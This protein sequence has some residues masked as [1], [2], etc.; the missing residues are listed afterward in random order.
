MRK[1]SFSQIAFA[2][3]TTCAIAGNLFV[4]NPTSVSANSSSLTRTDISISSINK[5]SKPVTRLSEKIVNQVYKQARTDYAGNVK[6]FVDAKRVPYPFYCDELRA[7]RNQP[8][9]CDPPTNK[10]TW[11]ITVDTYFERLV[12]YVRDTG[13]IKL[14]TREYLG[15]VNKLP[16]HV[17][18]IVLEDARKNWGLP[19]N[20]GKV[21]SVRAN[22]EP[23]GVDFTA[24]P[25]EPMFGGTHSG[26]RVWEVIIADNTTRWTYFVNQK[27]PR[28]LR[29]WSQLNYAFQSTLSPENGLAI[30]SRASANFRVD[31]GQ[32]LITNV[33]NIQVDGCFGLAA[34][35]EACT[36]AAFG[37]K[38]VTVRVNNR[39][40]AVYRIR[41]G[42]DIIALEGIKNMPPRTDSLTNNLAEKIITNASRRLR[43][44]TQNLRIRK[45]KL[46]NGCISANAQTYRKNCQVKVF[47]TDGQKNLAYTLNRNQQD[48]NKVETVSVQTN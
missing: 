30:I 37:A 10:D 42:S 8:L 40:T 12:Y 47:V 31:P 4:S 21:V 18:R 11:K 3:F 16:S 2:A 29:L 17:E 27:N 20:R 6:R 7:G 5:S 33:E 23:S 9:T 43:T 28:Q 34:P 19:T 36:K 14:G 24:L 38:R 22:I 41:G 46:S 1:I 32:I 13:T 39:D 44:Q 35:W 15:K 48:I 45:V 25:I 26:Q